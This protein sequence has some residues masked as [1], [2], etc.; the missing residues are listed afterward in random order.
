MMEEELPSVVAEDPEGG[1]VGD[2]ERCFRRIGGER[3]V[4]CQRL[5]VIV[6][7]GGG[8]GFALE[9][10]VDDLL[11]IEDAAGDAEL[12]ELVGEERDEDGAVALAVGVEKT[13]FERVE[14]VLKLRVGHALGSLFKDECRCGGFQMGRAVER[15]IE[16]RMNLAFGRRQRG[17]CAGDH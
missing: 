13:L 9:Q 15:F 10:G 17:G 1:T 8:A 14:V 7:D 16:L 3:C 12:L 4:L 6:A 5:D 11:A 2:D